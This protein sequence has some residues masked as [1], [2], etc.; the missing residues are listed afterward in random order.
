M[1][2]GQRWEQ[3]SE[4]QSRGVVVHLDA[5]AVEASNGCDQ[6][7]TQ[8]MAGRPATA[9]QSVKALEN[10]LTL[11]GRDSR[12]VIG[13]RNDGAAIVLRYLD[14]YLAGVAAVLDRVVNE[15]GHGIEQEVA[16]ARNQHGLVRHDTEMPAFL[17]CRGIEQLHHLSSYVG[18]VYGPER[19]R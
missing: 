19:R 10:L 3:K 9:F 14:R 17:L 7:E 12:P 2:P 5:S 6:T 15:I 16:V 11:A 8:P 1:S 4:L 13:D 18:Q